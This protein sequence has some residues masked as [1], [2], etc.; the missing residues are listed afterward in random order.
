MNYDALNCFFELVALCAQIGS[1]IKLHRDE[2][3]K[4]IFWPQV[5]W[6]GIWAVWCVAYYL[7]IGHNLSALVATLRC[8]ATFIW[9]LMCYSYEQTNHE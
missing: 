3:V 7:G 5:G 4:G 1:C 8:C 2:E 6:S 9:L